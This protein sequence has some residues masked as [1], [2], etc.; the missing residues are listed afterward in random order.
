MTPEEMAEQYVALSEKL[1]A[2]ERE[3][4]ELNEA[5]APLSRDREQKHIALSR[6]E[7]E[8]KELRAKFKEATGRE[9]RK[10]LR[11]PTAVA[12]EKAQG[13]LVG[14]M[15]EPGNLP[16]EDPIVQRRLAEYRDAILAHRDRTRN[17]KPE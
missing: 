1:T 7:E 2:L 16:L 3:I 13:A 8:R 6:V 9:I 4:T 17:T 5:I 10:H 14:A 12:I 11:P 15:C